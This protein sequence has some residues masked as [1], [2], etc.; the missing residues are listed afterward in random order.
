MPYSVHNV[1]T[2]NWLLDSDPSIRWQVLRDLTDEP[3][4]VVNAERARVARE[5][6]GAR[7]LELQDP[8]TGQW[9]SGTYQPEWTSTMNTLVLLWRMGV[10]PDSKAARKAVDLV[11]DKVKW[12][13]MPGD[14]W[15]GN[16]F[17]DGEVE[18][19][20]NGRVLSVGS[21]F[22]RDVQKLLGVI[23]NDQLEDGGWNCYSMYGSKRSSFHSTINVLEGLLEYEGATGDTSVRDARLKGQEYLLE[24][25]LLR[26]KSGGAI[27]NDEF[28]QLSFPPR[29]HFDLL[30][31][32]DYMRAAGAKP[33]ERIEEAIGILK[34]KRD[35]SGRWSLEHVHEGQVHF[36]L[37][38]GAGRRSRWNTLRGLR[39]LRWAAGF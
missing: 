21:Y 36:E 29:W 19:C 4:D 9:G 11:H 7:L 30:R 17:F 20:I 10:A 26:R 18:A 27:I 33:D 14:E 12:E 28:Q 37:D 24:R 23:L 5:G 32:L 6:W 34:G 25:S 39:V 38:D 13:G 16:D 35:D 3:A 1:K 2:I 22:D 15:H 8:A 31:G